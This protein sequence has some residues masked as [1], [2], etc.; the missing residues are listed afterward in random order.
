MSSSSA[1]EYV[2]PNGIQKREFLKAF[3]EGY[4]KKFSF[5]I[6]LKSSLDPDKI[7]MR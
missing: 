3:I 6:T 5:Y 4:N 7:A 1:L 2:F